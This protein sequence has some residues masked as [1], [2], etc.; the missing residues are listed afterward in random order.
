LM[1]YLRNK[2]FDE[3]TRAQIQ[4]RIKEVNG[5]E[6]SHGVKNFKTVRGEWKAARVWW[7]PEFVGEVEIPDVYVETSEVPF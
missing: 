2:R 1:N 6:E 5:G 4:E 3:Y 7:V